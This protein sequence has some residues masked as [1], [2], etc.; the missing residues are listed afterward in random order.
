MS[1]KINQYVKFIQNEQKRLSSSTV[2]A[3]RRATDNQQLDEMAPLMALAARVVAPAV[4]TAA[5]QM[6]VDTAAETAS[7]LLTK[8]KQKQE[9][10]ESE[11]VQSEGVLQK[12]GSFAK[13]YAKDVGQEVGHR[14]VQN[15]AGTR[16][17]TT[18]RKVGLLKTP[19]RDVDILQPKDRPE[20]VKAQNP[21]DGKPEFRRAPPPSKPAPTTSPSAPA[22]TA[23]KPKPARPAPTTS[24]SAPAVSEPEPKPEPTPSVK[25]RIK[26][27]PKKEVL[28]RFSSL[29]KPHIPSISEQDVVKAEPIKAKPAAQTKPTSQQDDSQLEDEPGIDPKEHG[30]KMQ[31]M[32][33]SPEYMDYVRQNQDKIRAKKAQSDPVQSATSTSTSVDVDAL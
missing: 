24:P 19:S 7:K 17:L 5:T 26:L 30:A 22:P 4:R 20:P 33:R 14:F 13:T 2:V 3:A 15:V 32:V 29:R 12:L 9:E 27:K 31:P 10:P 23:S 18:A 25:P 28:E 1:E 11:E 6:A 8:K 16:A 21:E